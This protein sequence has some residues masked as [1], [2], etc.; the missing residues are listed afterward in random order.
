MGGWIGG[1]FGFDPT[2]LQSLRDPTCNQSINVK[3]DRDPASG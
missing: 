1:L 2:R 3:D